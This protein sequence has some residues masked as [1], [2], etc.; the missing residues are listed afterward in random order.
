MKTSGTKR[1]RNGYL[2]PAKVGLPGLSG[3]FSTIV[4]DPPWRFLNRTGK[5]AP[6]HRRLS[7]YAT[8][9]IEEIC[10]LPVKAHAARPDHCYLWCPNTLVPRGLQI[11]SAWG[12]GYKT[13]IIWSK[14]RKDRGPDGRGVG[15][16]VSLA[17]VATTGAQTYGNQS[18]QLD[19]T[20]T[21]NDG[22]S[23][24]NPVTLLGNATIHAGGNIFRRASTSIRPLMGH[25]I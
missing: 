3:Q 6:E 16:S 2:Q 23:I 17:S 10:A 24:A 11:L 15:N 1:H 19:G 4:A 12:F 5:M 13:N 14:V 18:V 20:Y 21:T 8:M 9:G 25:S 22:F 7:R